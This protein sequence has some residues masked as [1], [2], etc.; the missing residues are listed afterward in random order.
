MR[1][2]V[3]TTPAIPADSTKNEL[4]LYR[5]LAALGVR[6]VP[7]KS[8]G[9]YTVDAWIPGYALAVEGDGCWAHGCEAEGYDEERPWEAKRRAR[10]DATLLKKHGL[11]CVHIWQ[12]DM[13]DDK[14]ALKAVRDAL[15]PYVPAVRDVEVF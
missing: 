1:V 9:W 7:Q 2:L 5:A 12:H 6:F 13:L 15:A 3:T 8:F 11:L 4:R 10:R 14:Q